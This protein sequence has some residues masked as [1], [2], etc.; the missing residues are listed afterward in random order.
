[1]N[2][3]LRLFYDYYDDY[4]VRLKLIC[5][6]RVIHDDKSLAEQSIRNGNLILALVLAESPTTEIES[7]AATAK[8]IEN[9]KA[10]T[11]LLATS[12]SDYMQVKTINKTIVFLSTVSQSVFCFFLYIVGGSSRQCHTH[13]RE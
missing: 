5:N 8:Q 1:M 2:V 7:A 11:Q 4:I 9:V 3:F 13:T 12:D 10:D 6:G